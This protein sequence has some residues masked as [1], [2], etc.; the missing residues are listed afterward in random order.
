MTSVTHRRAA[1]FG[2]RQSGDL[3]ASPVTVGVRVRRVAGPEHG[4]C[5]CGW[6]RARAGIVRPVSAGHAH[7]LP[8]GE[9]GATVAEAL[10]E[11]EAGETVYLTRAGRPIAAL[12]PITELAELQHA[13]DS[14]A[15]ADA[16]QIGARPGPRIPHQVVEAMMSADDAAHDA[17]AGALDAR[18]DEDLPPDEVTAIWEAIRARRDA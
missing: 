18:A 16:L 5:R 3:N 17:M 8:A 9:P 7:E 12:V 15:I 14:A 1:A 6:D 10:A 11:V 13:F 2:C 4:L